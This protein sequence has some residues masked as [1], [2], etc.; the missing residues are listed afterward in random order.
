MAIQKH[1]HIQLYFYLKLSSFRF[2]IEG[3]VCFEV[4]TEFNED[5]IVFIHE[6]S[7]LLQGFSLATALVGDAKKGLTAFK[8]IFHVRKRYCM[9][10]LKT[11]KKEYV[12]GMNNDFK[13]FL[14]QKTLT[15]YAMC[16]VATAP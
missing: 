8:I 10:C 4:F 2:S 7:L 9:C 13:I 1:R 11:G 16:L 3:S 6:N 15:M 5:I 14:P 12:E